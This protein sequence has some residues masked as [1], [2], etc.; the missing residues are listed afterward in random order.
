MGAG[1]AGLLAARTLADHVAE[2][3]V[4]ER[5]ELAPGSRPRRGVPQGRHA[6]LLLGRG[7]EVIEG[8]LPGFTGE[9]VRRGGV[10]ADVPGDGRIL[11]G[12]GLLL[13]Y[14]SG[15]DV[16]FASRP[17]LE[18]VVRES[19]GSWPGVRLQDRTDA[20]GLVAS[21]GRVTGLRTRRREDGHEEVLAADLVV[22]AAGRSPSAVGWLADLG[23]PVPRQE[24]VGIDLTYVTRTYR[25][26]PAD[27]DGGSFLL[28]SP[29]PP[30]LR[31]ATVLV[32]EGGL[33]I[34]ALTGLLGE[35]PPE[36][37]DGFRRFAESLPVR[38]LADLLDGAEPVGEPSLAHFSGSTRRR[39]EELRDVPEGY[40][41][42]GDAIS[43]FNPVYG[44]GMTVAAEES[45]LLG[46]ELERGLPG[47][48]RRF[49]RAAAKVVDVPWTMAVTSDLRHPG[50]RGRRGLGTRVLNAYVVRLVRGARH[51]RV[52]ADAFVRTN[53]LVASP[54]SLLRPSV[55]S[56]VVLAG[57]PRRPGRWRSR[58]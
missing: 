46:R 42:C 6:H 11:L 58:R 44:Q 2:V 54:L 18:Q 27:L 13:R 34:V 38:D 43:S 9:V 1:M 50:V 40:L 36:D 20:V 53:N 7:R 41:V 28:V 8:L 21:A 5:D 48:P 16:V 51:D 12:G 26:R 55:A 45:L 22:N 31:G 56:R 49:Y 10:L 47:L 25:R 17:L 37:A 19:V 57:L 14:R 33:W 15:F 39:F 4:V 35:R 23:Y 24:S 3:V 52:L 30:D 29:E 32:R